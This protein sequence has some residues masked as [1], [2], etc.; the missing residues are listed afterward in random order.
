[1]HK[2][3]HIITFQYKVQIN[4]FSFFFHTYSGSEKRVDTQW[5]NEKLVC[6]KTQIEL[7]TKGELDGR[8]INSP[9]MSPYTCYS[10]SWENSSLSRQFPALDHYRCCSNV[11]VEMT[12]LSVLRWFR[13]IWGSFWMVSTVVPLWVSTALPSV[14]TTLP[15][16]KFTTLCC[17]YMTSKRNKNN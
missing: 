7:K 2:S 9:Y 8:H 15:S 14:S 16:P 11:N 12:I 4:L 13:D 1:M 3:K 6:W 17:A 10:T 5:T